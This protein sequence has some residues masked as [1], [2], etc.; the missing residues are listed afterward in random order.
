[1]LYRF[2]YI[3]VANPFLPVV[4]FRFHPLIKI[5]LLKNS[6]LI[7]IEAYID[8]G[9]QWC[10]FNNNFAKQLGIKDY[11]KTKEFI[12][13]SG[14]GGER[15]E[16]TGYFHNLKLVVFKNIRKLRL[17]DAWVIETKIGFLEKPIGFAGILGVYGFLDHFSFRTNIPEGYFELEPLFE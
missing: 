16:N 4:K 12:P 9:S 2:P 5:G 14:I 10:L 13:I 7:K 17:K 8:T 3:K 1:M 15:Q 11:K 6:N